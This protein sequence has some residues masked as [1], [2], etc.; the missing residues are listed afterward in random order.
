MSIS[1]NKRKFINMSKF[2]FLENFRI[3]VDRIC[4]YGVSPIDCEKGIESACEFFEI[5]LPALIADMTENPQ[6]Q[7]MFVDFNP[8]SFCDDVICYHLE[9][10]KGLG[11]NSKDSF[12][13]VMT[14][15]CAHRILQS[16]TLPG[17]DNGQWEEELCCDFFMGV[18]ASIE[19]I[20]R[21]AFDSVRMGL[22]KG[23][24]SSTHPSGIL[25]D[26]AMT[27]GNMTGNFDLIQNRKR[28]IPEYLAIFE[29]WRQNN[30]QLI[31]MEQKPFFQY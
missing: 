19:K 12:T 4:R 23:G 29:R 16:T 11:V 5:P 9:Q 25:R 14:H 22:S 10:L 1:I 30:I 18:R 28:T 6:G 21:K 13:L 7:T 15:E 8:N 31:E 2:P 3:I 27:A 24:G 20:D 26:A 17:L